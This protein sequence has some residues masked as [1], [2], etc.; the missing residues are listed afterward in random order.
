[1]RPTHLEDLHT[2][3]PSAPPPR[4]GVQTQLIFSTETVVQP[5]LCWMTVLICHMLFLLPLINFLFMAKILLI[6]VLKLVLISPGRATS[7]AAPP[8]FSRRSSDKV[9]GLPSYLSIRSS[10][11]SCSTLHS[12]SLL[13]PTLA[14]PAPASASFQH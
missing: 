3:A 13:A 10:K 4:Q 11:T 9:F 1:M 2:P 14:P 12:P 7:A 5:N 6:L 8:L